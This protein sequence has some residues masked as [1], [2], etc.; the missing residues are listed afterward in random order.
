MGLWSRLFGSKTIK[1][2]P[3]K[4]SLHS[5]TPRALEKCPKCSE[6]DMTFFEKINEDQSVFVCNG[7]ARKHG[8]KVAIVLRKS[9]GDWV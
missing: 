6:S 2:E 9:Q 7:C 8:K 4:P 5:K 3:D 1:T